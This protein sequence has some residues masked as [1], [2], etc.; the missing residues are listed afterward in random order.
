MGY[1]VGMGPWGTMYY[2]T[3]NSLFMIAI[4]FA[5]ADDISI[6]IVVQISNKE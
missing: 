4:L 1:G 3:I 6:L 5:I 2:D